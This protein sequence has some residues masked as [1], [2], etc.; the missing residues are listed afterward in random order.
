VVFSF[1]VE[2]HTVSVGSES[3]NANL[4]EERA[5]AVKAFLM[6]QGVPEQQL[7]TIGHGERQPVASN[8]SD[9]GRQRNRRVEVINRGAGQ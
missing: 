8:E 1:S 2:G 9:A 3:Y 6:A 5:A 4:S 7:A